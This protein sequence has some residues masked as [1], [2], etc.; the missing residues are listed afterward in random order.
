MLQMLGALSRSRLRVELRF[1]V[2]CLLALEFQCIGVRLVLAWLR[3][4]EN[5]RG[6]RV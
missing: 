1:K 6:F 3:N 2:L 5:I 4:N